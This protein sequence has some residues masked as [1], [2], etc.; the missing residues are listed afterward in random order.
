M[1]RKVWSLFLSEENNEIWEFKLYAD[2]SVCI[3]MAGEDHPSI[4]GAGGWQ[5]F[6]GVKIFQIH[7]LIFIA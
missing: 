4:V 7:G 3:M 1:Y 5:Q 6:Y 2:G